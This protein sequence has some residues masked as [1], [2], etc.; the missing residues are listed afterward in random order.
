MKSSTQ[1]QAKYAFLGLFL[2]LSAQTLG[3]KAIEGPGA[4][5]LRERA[6]LEPPGLPEP[7][8]Q[9]LKNVGIA[10]SSLSVMVKELPSE[11]PH[12]GNSLKGQD[13]TPARLPRI[14]MSHLPSQL[15]TPASLMKLVTTQ[16]ALDL[17]G[18]NYTWKTEVYITGPIEPSGLLVGDVIIRGGLDPKLSVESATHLLQKL[19]AM[20]VQKIKGDVIVDK[21]MLD[22]PARDP[23]QFD[24]EPLKPYNVAADA[25]LINFNAILMTFTPDPWSG[26]A[27]VSI[28]PPL[29]GLTYPKG[30][31]LSGSNCL[32]YRKE[33]RADFAQPLGI[34]FSGSYA[35]AC[36]TKVWPLA[37]AKP[38]EFT[39][40]ALAGLWKSLQGEIEGVFK[41]GALPAHARLLWTE[42]SPPLSDVVKDMNKYSNNVMAQHLFLSL[43][44]NT[45]SDMPRAAN[46]NVSREVVQGW[47]REKVS[48]TPLI[49][50]QGSGL[51]RSER[52]SAQGLSDLLD[53]MWLS[54][55]MS[56]VMASLPISGV[57]GTLKSR[58]SIAPAHLKT[59]SLKDVNG[60]AGIVQDRG[61][62]RHIL[63]AII[64][65]PK[66]KEGQVV[67][68]ALI[69]WVAN[70]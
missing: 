59:G 17:L 29:A 62:K 16:A 34:T 23:G 45:S 22:E 4:E 52:I 27:H 53:H 1:T 18:P 9:L 68:E 55:F 48:S 19:R 50:E 60:V 7:I 2:L 43:S 58:Q 3:A 41:V 51:S 5:A 64:N 30:V 56:E 38:Q 42:S 37:F 44:L 40:R 66:A 21:S 31:P 35:K 25:L 49:I 46:E 61:Q 39:Q 28:E 69:Q 36:G 32:D 65:D 47:W 70:Q 54:P 13:R 15:R 63:V 24:G 20:G 10:P 14:E 26:V 67:L 33:L 6:K 57:D 12:L 11:R 8:V